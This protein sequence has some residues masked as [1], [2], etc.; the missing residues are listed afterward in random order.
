[1]KKVLLVTSPAKHKNNF[2]TCSITSPVG[3]LM[4][5]CDLASIAAVLRRDEI[6]PRILDIR[7]H[8]R[9]LDVLRQEILAWRPDAVM[10]NMGTASAMEDY[11]ILKTALDV[12]PKRICFGFHAMALPTEMFEKGAT[13]ILVGHPE[14]AASAA[15]NDVPIGKGLWSPDDRSAPPGWVEPMDELPYPALDLLDIHAYHSLIMG[16]E[17]FSILLA[18]RGCPFSCTYCVIPFSLGDKVR[19][20]SPKRT[21][22]EMLRD[23]KDYGVRSFFFIDSAVNLNPS[24]LRAVCEEIIHT[25]LPIRWCANMRV[26]P[27]D[28]GMLALMKRAGCFRIFFGVEDLDRVKDLNRRTTAEATRTAFELT[29]AAGIETVAFILLVPGIDQSE[30]EMARRIVKMVADLKADALQ[31]NLAIPYPG[32]HMYEEFLKK[33]AMSRDWSLYD[34]AGTGIPYPS[35]LDLVSVRRM[36]YLRHFVA[37]PGYVLRTIRSTEIRSIG[38]FAINSFRV[39]WG[40]R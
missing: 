22:E 34:P 20:Y 30:K 19:S 7:L 5:P 31:C 1:M 14:Y 39:L 17:P 6:E 28:A 10:T 9:P 15:V 24:W 25:K 38:A 18:N 16:N 2:W 29:K 35:E 33:Y 8:D 27:V 23:Y 11:G 36:V 26:S 32:S 12:V 3:S 4:P 21:V 13:H 37:N 40:K